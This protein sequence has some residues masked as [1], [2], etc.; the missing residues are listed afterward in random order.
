MN[1]TIMSE[2]TTTLDLPRFGEFTYA[3]SE[4]IEFPWG[5]P[6]F[7]KLHHFV[8]LSLDEQ[9]N[10]IWLQS[11]DDLNVALPT[12]DPWSVFP[13]YDPKVPPYATAA[14]ELNSPEDFSILCVV[15]VTKDAEDMYMNLL[16]PLIVNLK[17]RRGRQITLEGSEYSIRTLIPRKSP[18]ATGAEAAEEAPTP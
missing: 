6:G 13:D 14:L 2:S 16:A 12:A 5:I 3:D 18:V 9:P 4:V 10:F 15:V 11:L 8:A 17:S 1:S 7:S